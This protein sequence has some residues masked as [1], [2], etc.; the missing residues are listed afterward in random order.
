M[1]FSDVSEA[2]LLTSKLSQDASIS[3]PTQLPDVSAIEKETEEGDL[4]MSLLPF[5]PTINPPIDDEDNKSMASAISDKTFVKT[6]L[7]PFSSDEDDG[8]E[9]DEDTVIEESMITDPNEIA[10]PLLLTADRSIRRPGAPVI[11]PDSRRAE[12]P[13]VFKIPAPPKCE[14]PVAEEV[15]VKRRTT[16]LFRESQ[17]GR[18]TLFDQV[19]MAFVLNRQSGFSSTRGIANETALRHSIFDTAGSDHEE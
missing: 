15:N 11:S 4:S 9:E 3:V 6:S 17:N 8:D 7:Q 2:R 10:R 19:S 12:E 14:P 1:H 5:V 13:S 16:R 18:I